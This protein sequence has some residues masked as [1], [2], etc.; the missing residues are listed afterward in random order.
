MDNDFDEKD[1][2]ESSE[3]IDGDERAPSIEHIHSSE[4][5]FTIDLSLTSID[6]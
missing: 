6:I 5:L 3:S 1:S 2:R 4:G